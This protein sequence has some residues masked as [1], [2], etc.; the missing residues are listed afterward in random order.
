MGEMC[1][2]IYRCDDP[3][4]PLYF[5]EYE[6]ALYKFLCMGKLGWDALRVLFFWK[7]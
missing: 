6:D 5:W 1:W 3:D 7:I 2:C 4:H